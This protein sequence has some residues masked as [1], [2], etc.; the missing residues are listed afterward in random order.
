MFETAKQYYVATT[1]DVPS[2]TGTRVHLQI[3]H[4]HAR[5]FSIGD[6]CPACTST[7]LGKPARGALHAAISR[8]PAGDGMIS[9]AGAPATGSAPQVIYP[10]R[11]TYASE[12]S[13]SP[14]SWR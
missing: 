8:N 6:Q 13:S 11:R 3:T 12:D 4:R 9:V 7:E 5:S 1:C 14:G 2:T 10:V